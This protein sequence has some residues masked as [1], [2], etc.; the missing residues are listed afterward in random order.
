MKMLFGSNSALSLREYLSDIC[1]IDPLFSKRNIN[2]T[3]RNQKIIFSSLLIIIFFLTIA[4]IWQDFE[5]MQSLKH[6]VTEILVCSSIL[7]AFLYLQLQNQFLHKEIS[8]NKNEMDKFR[9]EAEKWKKKNID[10]IEGLS[11]AIDKQLSSW[12]LSPSEK[13]IALLL[14]KGLS[15]KEIAD[16]RS[17][18]EKTI[19]Q[20][21]TSIYQKSSLSGRAE[22]SAYFLEDLL[23]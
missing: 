7:I 8:F 22:L 4:D 16:I 23:K 15:S 17:V 20:Q 19:R 18:S 13:E 14:L 5:E 10:F 3:S 11:A 6:M 9:E 1:P 21:A 2:M 12:N